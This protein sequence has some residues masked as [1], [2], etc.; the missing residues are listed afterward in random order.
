MRIVRKGDFMNENWLT[1]AQLEEKTKIPHQTIRRYF[2]RH[3]H[4][5][6]T[7][8]QHRSILIHEDGLE[9]LLT[10]REMYEK[11]YN[12]QRIETELSNHGFLTTVIIE[13]DGE[14]INALEVLE[15][16]QKSNVQLHEKMEKQ[17][18]QMKKQ[19]EFNSLLINQ[20][21][22]Q[23]EYIESTL[24]KRD[25]ILINSLK[26]TLETKK[27]V[28]EAERQVSTSEEVKEKSWW[29]KIFSK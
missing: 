6:K 4:H 2:E 11:N 8:K 15:S 17:A 23:Q 19:E 18:E 21:K 12:V 20:L 27:E 7:K 1:F 16:L 25:E 13:D 14:K 26:E 3:G 29:N 22:K 9:T 5:L 24:K 28:K 10:I